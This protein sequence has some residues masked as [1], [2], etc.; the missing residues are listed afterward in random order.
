LY[1]NGYYNKTFLTT[2]VLFFS[3]R[4]LKRYTGKRNNSKGL[5][6]YQL[7]FEFDSL[8]VFFDL[9][10]L[11]APLLVNIEALLERMTDAFTW[12]SCTTL[13]EMSTKPVTSRATTA[14]RTG[15]VRRGVGHKE[16]PRPSILQLNTEGLTA[17]KIAVIEQLAYKNKAFIIVLQEIHCR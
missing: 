1:S 5:S 4:S 6:C 11:S 13:L 2:N 3:V 14:T 8:Q 9:V 12:P 10:H 7:C 17:D 15:C 16:G